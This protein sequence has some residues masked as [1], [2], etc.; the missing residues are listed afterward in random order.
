MDANILPIEKKKEKGAQP[1]DQQ[2][3]ETAKPTMIHY[4]MLAAKKTFKKE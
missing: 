4:G 3:R 1:D 2:K